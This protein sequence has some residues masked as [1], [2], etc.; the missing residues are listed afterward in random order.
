LAGKT[1]WPWTEESRRLPSQKPDGSQWPKL[2][3]VTPSLN[4]GKFIEET[5][6]SILLQGY[7]DIEY[8]VFD[9]GSRDNSVAIIE[10]YS[11]WLQYWV[12]EPDGGQSAAINRGLYMA[13]GDFAAWINSDDMLCKNALVEHVTENDCLANTIYVGTCL[14]ID[15]DGKCL[16]SHRGRVLSLDDLLR[17]RTVWRSGRHID[18]P[19]VLFPR[20]LALSIGGLR[21]DN[22][23]TMDYELWGKFFLAGA[24]FQYTDIPFGMFR[25]HANQKTRNGL[26]ITHSLLDTAARLAIL[27]DC[28]SEQVRKEILEDLNAYKEQYAKNYWKNSG[29]LAKIGLPPMVVNP[30]RRMKA[31]LR[32]PAL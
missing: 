7:P 30:I 3:V 25:T 32:K 26:R 20:E 10:K 9:G 27:A 11:P 6:R 16:Y 29:R 2:T 13:S 15:A 23:F 31:R 28:F 14:Y 5:I 24:S 22:H 1:G 8:F 19:A 4:Q 18:Q 21:H 17:I 12:S